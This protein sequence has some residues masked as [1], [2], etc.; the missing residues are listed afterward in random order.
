M[1]FRSDRLHHV[2]RNTKHAAV[3]AA[4]LTAIGTFIVTTQTMA[5]ARTVVASAEIKMASGEKVGTIRFENAKDGDATVIVADFAFPAGSIQP[6][7]FHG[8]HIHANDA[9]ANGIG[10]VADATK[11]SNTWFV[12]ADGHYKKEPGDNHG[13]HAG[14]L[15]TVYI[16]RDRTGRVET[17][18]DRFVANQLFDRT[19]IFHADPDNY[20]NIPKGTGPNQYTANSPDAITATNKTGN[21][22]DRMACGAIEVK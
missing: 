19:V 7:T 18:I 14:D 20:G 3:G 1:F 6:G 9:A 5:S 10:C 4:A 17:K 15:A 11:A 12:S 13:G 21:A 2:T 22:G 8:L 16:N